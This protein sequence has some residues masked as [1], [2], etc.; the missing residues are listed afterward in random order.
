[1]AN[2]QRLGAIVLSRS[3]GFP[4]IMLGDTGGSFFNDYVVKSKIDVIQA[5][6]VVVHGISDVLLPTLS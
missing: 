3:A 5:D 1:M 2:G 6:N 4:I